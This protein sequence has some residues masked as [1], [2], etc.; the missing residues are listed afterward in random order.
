MVCVKLGCWKARGTKIVIK[1]ALFFLW[2][3]DLHVGTAFSYVRII[4]NEVIRGCVTWYLDD[5]R[6][7]FIFIILRAHVVIL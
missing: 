6:I 1:L 4:S 5:M 3:R 2:K 7:M